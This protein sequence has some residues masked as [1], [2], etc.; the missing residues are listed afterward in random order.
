MKER[1][2]RPAR[3]GHAEKGMTGNAEVEGPTTT[4]MTTVRFFDSISGQQNINPVT[5]DA[6]IDSR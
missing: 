1:Y 3:T 6:E 5:D 2:V 4:T